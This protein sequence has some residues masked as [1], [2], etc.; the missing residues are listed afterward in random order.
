MMGFPMMTIAFREAGQWQG[1]RIGHQEDRGEEASEENQDYQF[2]YSKIRAKNYQAIGHQRIHEK[3][4]STN[5][6]AKTNTS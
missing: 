5:N 3:Q 4:K 1:R 6:R 2:Y